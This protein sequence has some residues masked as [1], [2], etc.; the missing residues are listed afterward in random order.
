MEVDLTQVN[1]MPSE[2]SEK[3]TSKVHF[4]GGVVSQKIDASPISPKIQESP[5]LNGGIV[6]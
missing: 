4:T 1:S 6:S 5:L 2:M 3:G